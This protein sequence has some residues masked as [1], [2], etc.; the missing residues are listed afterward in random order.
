M[1][2]SYQIATTEAGLGPAERMRRVGQAAG[3][4]NHGFDLPRSCRQ[5]FRGIDLPGKSLLEIGCGK[6]VLCLWAALHGAREVIGLEPLAQGA[7]DSSEC[8]RDFQAMA[9]QLEL[10][11]A[12][13]SPLAI[14]DY[15]GSPNRF[16]IVLSV[17][18]INHLDEKNCIRLRESPLAIQAYEKIFRR[19]ARMM[20]PGGRLIVVDAA[21]RNIFGDLGLHNPMT[22]CVEWFKHHQPEYWARL[23]QNCGFGQTNIRWVSGRLLRYMGIS[24]LPKFLAYFGQSVFRLEMRRVR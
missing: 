4:W 9:N 3:L 8:H 17:A 12:K 5:I 19:V 6:G 20:K 15:E 24:A 10:P 11:Q 1:S 13:I 18:S 7:F 22:P 2:T 14:Q 23:L 16:D 21:R